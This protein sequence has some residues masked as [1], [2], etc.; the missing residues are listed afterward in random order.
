ML[1]VQFLVPITFKSLHCIHVF[2]SVL[3]ILF[4]RFFPVFR[5]ICCIT[6]RLF[7]ASLELCFLM[8]SQYSGRGRSE[9][10]DSVMG[11]VDNCH[12]RY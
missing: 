5:R 11:S 12:N 7:C 3:Q 8:Y 9:D 1:F 6:E 4:K 10:L 2:G